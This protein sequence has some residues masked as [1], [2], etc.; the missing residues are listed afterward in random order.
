MRI[1]KKTSIPIPSHSNL[2][3]PNPILMNKTY[4]F[5]WDS[6]F[7]P[8]GVRGTLRMCKQLAR[9]RYLTAKSSGVEPTT[10]KL[11]VQ[12]P[13]HY[14]TWNIRRDAKYCNECVCLSVRTQNPK[15]AQPNFTKF[16]CGL[17]VAVAR[18]SSDGVAMLY[19]YFRFYG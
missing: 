4:T 2:A 1:C 3:I 14:I 18:S 19:V 8:F 11:Q 12:R 10:S 15:T 6:Q 5:P 17:P 13:D 16:L 7:I 9:G